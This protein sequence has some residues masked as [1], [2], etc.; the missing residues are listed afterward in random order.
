MLQYI[1]YQHGRK[2]CAKILPSVEKNKNV[3]RDKQRKTVLKYKRIP[4]LLW[5]DLK[6]LF[7]YYI[8][9]PM[10]YSSMCVYYTS[11]HVY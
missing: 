6:Y 1:Y 5:V 3:P 8:S 4:Q 10:Y 2:N 9:I 11:M 7:S